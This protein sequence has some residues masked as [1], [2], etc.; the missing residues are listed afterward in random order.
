[1]EIFN[2]GIFEVDKIRKAYTSGDN[3]Y[4]YNDIE[5]LIAVVEPR[6]G[7]TVGKSAETAIA[8]GRQGVKGRESYLVVDVGAKVVRDSKIYRDRPHALHAQRES[9]Y[10]K[11][12][13]I[14]ALILLE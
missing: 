6:V 3:Q 9:Q 8:E 7:K 14:R 11:Y 13:R 12:H 2:C 10:I 4:G 5:H 1:M